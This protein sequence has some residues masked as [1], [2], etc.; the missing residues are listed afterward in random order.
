MCSL[1]ENNFKGSKSIKDG[2]QFSYLGKKGI[3]LNGVKRCEKNSTYIL[4]KTVAGCH[5]KS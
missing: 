3:D 2:K 1:Q 5:N 4:Q